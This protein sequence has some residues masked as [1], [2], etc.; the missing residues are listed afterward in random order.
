MEIR[1]SAEE[2]VIREIRE[3]TGYMVQVN[4][5]I[6]VYTKYFHTYPN[7]DQVQTVGMFFKCS[8]IGGSKKINGEETLDLKFSPLNQ[9]PTLFNKQHR[10]CLDDILKGREAVYR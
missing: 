1:E 8:T 10:D 9:M 2:T 6:G 4:E 3:E 7:G 5:L